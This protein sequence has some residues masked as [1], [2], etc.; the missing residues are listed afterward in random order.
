[1]TKFQQEMKIRHRIV[2]FDIDKNAT[3]PK[4]TNMECK[5]GVKLDNVKDM[6]THIKESN[7]L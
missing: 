7:K 1:M 4:A 3:P 5:C 2:H 6:G